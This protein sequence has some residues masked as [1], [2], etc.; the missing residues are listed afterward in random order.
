MHWILALF[1]KVWE[2][3]IDCCRKP[4]SF[5]VFSITRNCSLMMYLVLKTW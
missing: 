1:L 4:F 2:T 5:S 3:A